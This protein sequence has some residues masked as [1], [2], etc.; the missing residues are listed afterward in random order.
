MSQGGYSIDA[1]AVPDMATLHSGIS[2]A[3]QWYRSL[4]SAT[5]AGIDAATKDPGEASIA[6]SQAGVASGIDSLL[7]A[8]DQ[9][10]GTLGELL[11]ASQQALQTAQQGAAQPA[12]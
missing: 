10:H 4:D 3:L 11:Q 12:S 2:S 8:F 1:S 6:L 5:Q 9:L 7:Q